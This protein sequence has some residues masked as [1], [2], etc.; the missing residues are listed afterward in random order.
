MTT[1]CARILLLADTHLGFDMP[2]RPRVDRR[3]RGPDFF[4]NYERVLGGVSGHRVDL[5]VHGGDL[6]FRRKVPARLVQ[7]A[8]IP[9]KRLA[10]SGVPVYLVPGNHERSEIPYEMLALHPNIH[11]FDRPRTFVADVNGIRIALGGFPY[12]R[13]GVQGQFPS[14][15][16]AAGFK[17]VEADVRLL[18]VHQCFE[19]AAVG[20]S[21]YTF[22][23]ADD[24]VRI[25]DVPDDSAAVLSGHIHRH[26]VL[27]TDLVG[28][29]APAPVLYP[30]SIERT[31][32]AELDEAKGYLVLEVAPGGVPG[33]VLRSWEFHPLPVRPMLVRD[34]HVG[35]AESTDLE[36][37]IR[38]TVASVPEDAIL[39]IRVHG[40]LGDRDRAVVAAANLRAMVPHTMNVEVRVQ[41]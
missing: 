31:S 7:Q 20:P 9:L 23:Y 18:C 21:E 27:T 1:D 11:V 35:S 3:R 6:L 26:Q 28:R 40:P 2:L 38:D 33:G 32:F 39:R 34:L 10:D 25:R 24:V 8:M 15:L 36:R 16:T 37:A 22:R 19:G 29:E 17:E 41:L 12:C 5:L 13:Y 30:G 14:L 4:D